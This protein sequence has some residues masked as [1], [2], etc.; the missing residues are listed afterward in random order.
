MAQKALLHLLGFAALSGLMAI[1]PAQAQDLA[2]C[3]N[4]CHSA[5]DWQ[6]NA[7]GYS[8]GQC[9][10][11]AGT[12]YNNCTYDAYDT[13]LDCLSWSSTSPLGALGCVVVL[14][15]EDDACGRVLDSR[16]SD[17]DSEYDP[18]IQ[19]E[20]QD[21][22]DCLDSCSRNYWS[23]LQRAN[24]ALLASSLPELSPMPAMQLPMIAFNV[25]RQDQKGCAPV[26]GL[27]P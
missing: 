13:Y 19:Q 9:Y 4:N 22:D 25:K 2:T 21:R 15:A 6:I 17:C 16:K 3:N 12:E 1:S 20:T 7:L 24:R 27:L 26:F 23:R 5:Y 8:K 11:S 10:N 14:G 18:W